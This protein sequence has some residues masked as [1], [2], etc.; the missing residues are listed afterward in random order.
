MIN[1]NIYIL[2]LSILVFTYIFLQYSGT[3]YLPPD[4]KKIDI[5]IAVFEEDISWINKLPT[6]LYNHIHIYNKGGPK[7]Y[8]FPNSTVIDLPNVGYEAGTYLYHIINNYNSLADTIL[9]LPGTAWTRAYKRH[10]MIKTIHALAK[11][12]DSASVGYN[13]EYLLS[14]GSIYNYA[15]SLTAE[16]EFRIKSYEYSNEINRMHS[17]DSKLVEAVVHPYGNWFKHIFK[18][19]NEI[20]CLTYNGIFAASRHNILKRSRE[21]YQR[22]LRQIDYQQSEVGHYI[23][24]SWTS[25]VSTPQENCIQHTF[26]PLYWVLSG[27]IWI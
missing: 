13:T 3:I 9:F 1:T 26:H 21:F 15:A 17:S 8:S 27:F 2:I 10:K 18:D 7:N 14:L 4:F 6:E 16:K 12:R 25:I 22:L 11:G 24:R 5:V 19:E 23:E 20:R